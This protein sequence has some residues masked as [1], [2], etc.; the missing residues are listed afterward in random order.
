MANWTDP[1]GSKVGKGRRVGKGS[2]S[3]ERAGN[4]SN[5]LSRLRQSRIVDFGVSI[6]A[7]DR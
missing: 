1:I 2:L 5:H 6:R 4:R 7:C 3:G